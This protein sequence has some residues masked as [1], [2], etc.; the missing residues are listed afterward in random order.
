MNSALPGEHYC[1]KHQ[2]NTSHYDRDSCKVCKV[3][4]AVKGHELRMRAVME[5]SLIQVEVNSFRRLH[6][7]LKMI[8]ED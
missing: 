4:A 3:A 1:K 2:G 6:H 5:E 8:L 7:V